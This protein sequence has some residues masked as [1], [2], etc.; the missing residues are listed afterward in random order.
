MKHRA[1]SKRLKNYVSMSNQVVKKNEALI[2][3]MFFC[4][5]G[6][7]CTFTK[8]TQKPVISGVISGNGGYNPT[9]RGY[10]IDIT[11]RGPF[12]TWHRRLRSLRKTKP[13]ESLRMQ[14]VDAPCV[15]IKGISRYS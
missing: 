4:F 8:W 7:P 3:L 5:E 10:P 2:D 12:C 6:K 14:A 15:L 9:Y 11:S 1:T 13:G